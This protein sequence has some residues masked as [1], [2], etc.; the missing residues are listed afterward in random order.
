MNAPSSNVKPISVMPGSAPVEGTVLAI[1]GDRVSRRFVELALSM[2][3]IGV[4]LASDAGAAAEV[5]RTTV[6]D[7]ILCETSLSDMTGI[8]FLRRVIEDPRYQ[9]IPFVFL[10]ADAKSPSKIGAFRSGAYDYLVKPIDRDE[11][12]ARCM[13]ILYR[14]EK[15]RSAEARKPYT[16]AGDFKT[17]AFPD[18]TVMLSMGRQT[19]TLYVVT[20]HVQGTVLFVEGKPVQA[21]CGNIIG[22]QAFYTLMSQRAGHFEFDPT[23]PALSED[24]DVIE[25]SVNSLLMEGARLQDEDGRAAPP[26]PKK[27]ELIPVM[28]PTSVRILSGLPSPRSSAVFEEGLSDPFTLGELQLWTLEQLK[29]WTG[30]AGPDR[31]HVLLIADPP[32]ATSSLLALASAPSQRFMERSYTA[33]SKALGLTFYLPGGVEVDVLVVDIRNPTE[34]AGGLLQLPSLVVVAPPG[35]DLLAAGARGRGALE[36]LLEKLMPPVIVGVGT[37]TLRD[38]LADLPAVSNGICAM[39]LIEGKLGTG[40]G[41]LRSVLV[42]GVRLFAKQEVVRHE[43]RRV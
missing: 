1:D 24:A 38:S 5:L 16:L 37:T 13:S 34:F 7:L 40:A 22:P 12:A 42:E 31:F 33:E 17:L 6:V 29:K 27:L 4:E 18:L 19:G 14:H 43:A 25:Q 32:V 9:H 8:H 30:R 35:G 2:H 28:E 23:P 36:K 26:P 3:G 41:E 20:K 10:S 15:R 21:R 11:L 39:K